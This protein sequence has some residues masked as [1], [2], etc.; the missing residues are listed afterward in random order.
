MRSGI[1]FDAHRLVV[2]RKLVI[3]GVAIPHHMGLEGHSDADVLTHAIIDALLGAA[4]MGDIGT[5]FSSDDPDLAGV[6]STKLLAKVCE[7][8][9]RAGWDIDHVDSTIIAQAP[10]MS[11]YIG[12]MRDKISKVMEIPLTSVSIKATTTDGLGPWGREEGI[13]ALAVCNISRNDE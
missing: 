7:Y 9:R 8:V 4:S 1:G 10:R 12:A 13:A 5:L 11:P 3:G 2:G 6:D